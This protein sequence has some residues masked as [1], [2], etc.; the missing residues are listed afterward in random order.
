MLW[1]RPWCQPSKVPPIRAQDL[2]NLDQSEHSVSIISTNQS[3][4]LTVLHRFSADEAG[5]T[6]GLSQVAVIALIA[7]YSG[8]KSVSNVVREIV[9]NIIGQ[10]ISIG[11]ISI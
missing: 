5:R 2:D 8:T 11:Q 1:H 7:L 10:I 3:A 9:C 4:P 6:G